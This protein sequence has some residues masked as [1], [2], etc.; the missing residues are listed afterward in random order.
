MTGNKRVLRIR[1]TEGHE[2]KVTVTVPLSLARL[3]RIGGIADQVAARNGIDLDE[4]FRGIE[5][6][7]DGK[8]VDVLDERSGEHVEISIETSGATE[9]DTIS[10][11]PA[12]V[13]R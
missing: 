13:H 12:E 7:P 6:M 5:E 4:I 2:P 1:V 9:A 10:T 11:I 3:A 8:L